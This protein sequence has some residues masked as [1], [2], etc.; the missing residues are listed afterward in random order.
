MSKRGSGKAGDG[1]ADISCPD[2]AAMRK[3][4]LEH[5]LSNTDSVLE[6]RE[7]IECGEQS[8]AQLK[9][10]HQEL[11]LLC[12]EGKALSGPRVPSPCLARRRAQVRAPRVLGTWQ[13][14]RQRSDIKRLPA[15]F[16]DKMTRKQCNR[17]C[18]VAN[19]NDQF[20]MRTLLEAI[21]TAAARGS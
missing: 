1:Y 7:R 6:A 3:W 9:R 16:S 2:L 12:H 13:L 18:I 8:A 11:W 5:W 14:N 20:S 19:A 21:A 17:K 10:S 15:M 4:S